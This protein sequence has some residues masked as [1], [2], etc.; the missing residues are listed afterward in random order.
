[1]KAPLSIRKNAIKIQCIIL[2]LILMICNALGLRLPPSADREAAGF[3]ASVPG[4]EITPFI[5]N[6][7][8]F[9]VHGGWD[10]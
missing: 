2:I 5:V 6:G 3:S 4:E 9:R 10:T 8:Q 1:M 7:A